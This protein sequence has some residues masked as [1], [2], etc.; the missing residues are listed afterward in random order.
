[1]IRRFNSNRIIMEDRE[2]L[3]TLLF[4]GSADEVDEV[5]WMEDA[6]GFPA[7]RH[8][9]ESFS[10]FEE[11]CGSKVWSLDRTGLK[12]KVSCC[13]SPEQLVEVV[14]CLRSRRD[15]LEYLSIET[16]AEEY[17][18]AN[19]CDLRPVMNAVAELKTLKRLRVCCPGVGVLGALC[20]PSARKDE[21]SVF[22]LG[23]DERDMDTVEKVEEKEEKEGWE[24][25]LTTLFFTFSSSEWK[26]WNFQSFFDDLSLYRSLTHLNLTMTS[27]H[28]AD[29]VMQTLG[30][31]S[32]PGLKSLTLQG[33]STEE[34]G[35][36]LLAGVLQNLNR[37]EELD[38]S[39][40]VFTGDQE[41]VHY[42]ALASA[43][44]SLS[45][46]RVY[47]QLATFTPT[48]SMSSSSTRVDY[49]LNAD[50]SDLNI[51]DGL[52]L[53][54]AG[55]PLIEVI[56]IKSCSYSV[57]VVTE[58]LASLAI[59]APRHLRTLD[60]SSSLLGEDAS[61]W[62]Q[63]GQVMKACPSLTELDLSSNGIGASFWCEMAE[64]LGGTQLRKLN[65]SYNTELFRNKFSD[66][67]GSF[68]D[69]L[70]SCVGLEELGL[71]LVSIRKDG[72]AARFWEWVGSAPH[73]HRFELNLSSSIHYDI[74]ESALI[75]AN[76]LEAVTFK[77]CRSIE[78]PSGSLVRG[79]QTC[80]SLTSIGLDHYW[81]TPNGLEKMALM[82]QTGAFSQLRSLDISY[83]SFV[84]E[85]EAW[86]HIASIVR[87][88][89]N[90]TSVGYLPPSRGPH[91]DAVSE[92]VI[93]NAATIR[94]SMY[95]SLLECGVYSVF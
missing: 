25:E 33:F 56:S 87:A 62:I 59:L 89:P 73:L 76:R 51:K 86:G 23:E 67:G 6:D 16:V 68:V 79:L 18:G 12:L 44:S 32:L 27:T 53:A 37:I 83:A 82:A 46:L 39:G 72:D 47:R 52:L 91:V 40:G 55:C 24:S 70:H 42:S 65:M 1:M 5:S 30:S 26:E 66:L 20:L 80:E 69:V 64:A 29:L 45:S 85:D 43:I 38:L 92:A 77:H 34:K 63:L 4:E 11:A 50:T 3:G 75:S 61:L 49:G 15:R 60:L 36:M 21:G 14:E 90:I 54:V 88:C 10:A 7:L 2:N 28:L 95:F 48:L 41:G 22:S 57:A 35:I 84:S 9:V 78:L 94:R 71:V 93:R 17:L 74:I 13:A 8:D 31:C 81:G 58:F 19:D